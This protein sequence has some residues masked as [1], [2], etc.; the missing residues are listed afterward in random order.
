MHVKWFMSCRS[1]TRC[2]VYGNSGVPQSRVTLQTSVDT[3]P[4]DHHRGQ[5]TNHRARCRGGGGVTQVRVA[6][7]EGKTGNLWK[8]LGQSAVLAVWILET[9]TVRHPTSLVECE[10]S[11]IIAAVSLFGA[12]GRVVLTAVTANGWS[13]SDQSGTDQ[14][15]DSQET[16][17]FPLGSSLTH[18]AAV[19]VIM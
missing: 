14:Q 12:A 8:H 7:L 18:P 19:A 13:K 10:T 6:A 2:Y 11:I 17:H 4:H 3:P 1:W 9:L 15:T 16:L 5:Q